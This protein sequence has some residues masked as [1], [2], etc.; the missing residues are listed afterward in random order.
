MYKKLSSFGLAS[1]FAFGAAGWLSA[2]AVSIQIVEV[3]FPDGSIS[4]VASPEDGECT[5]QDIKNAI[6]WSCEDSTGKRVVSE[7]IEERAILLT[8]QFRESLPEGPDRKELRVLIKE[9]GSVYVG[10]A[11]EGSFAKEALLMCKL[12]LK[13]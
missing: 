8:Q 13:N 9:D 2:S 11:D 10:V 4:G 1:A 3:R 7:E 6:K 5:P 12:E